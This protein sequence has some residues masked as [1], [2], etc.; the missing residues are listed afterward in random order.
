MA[1]SS[2]YTVMKNRIRLL[3]LLLILLALAPTAF[4]QKRPPSFFNDRGACPFE[5]C[6]YR[7]WKTEKTTKLYER[8]DV[9]SRQVGTAVAGS[10]VRAVT[11]EVHTIPSRF[12][13]K[14]KHE[15]YQPGDVLWVY[16]YQG[17]G[18]FQVWFKGRM[19]QE[20]L[21][22]SPYGGS[23]GQRCEEKDQCWGELD[24]ELNSVWWI[25][26]RLPNG[27]TGWTKEGNNFS[28]SDACG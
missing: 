21:I 6:T 5:C 7:R 8:P 22:F 2:F 18:F 26:I 25:K 15:R 19:Y 9:R 17:E 10:R 27:R 28:G 3:T 11:G 13:V 23:T 24:K 1:A 14:K 12:I 4:S 16:T 20:E